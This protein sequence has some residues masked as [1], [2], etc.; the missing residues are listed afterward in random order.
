MVTLNNMSILNQWSS[1]Y[2]MLAN[3]LW[4][5]AMRIFI[6]TWNFTLNTWRKRSKT[7]DHTWKTLKAWDH[8][9]PS[10]KQL[11]IWFDIRKYRD[12]PSSIYSWSIKL[13]QECWNYAIK[14][15]G[16]FFPSNFTLEKTDEWCEIP[17]YDSVRW[18]L[19]NWCCSWKQKIR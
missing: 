17:G 8:T 6:R 18:G 12:N 1:L 14:R 7:S 4:T 11:W 10:L 2:F 19:E 13:C 5:K 15:C 3:G 9:W 16:Y